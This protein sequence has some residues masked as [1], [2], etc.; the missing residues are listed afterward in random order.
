MS[1]DLGQFMPDVAAALCGAPNKGLSKGD[2]LRYGSNGS[3]SVDLKKGTAYDHELEQG[4]GVLWLIKRHKGL[5]GADA[6]AFMRDDLHLPIP[7]RRQANGSNLPIIDDHPFA[8]WND[9]PRKGKPK[10][11]IVKTYDY[12]DYSGS[13]LYQVVRFEPKGFGQRR[14]SGL[15]DKSWVWG[16]DAGEFMRKGPGSDWIR[17][18][19]KNFT[20]WKFKERKEFGDAVPH[21]LYR[22][23]ELRESLIEDTIIFIP[24]GEKDV[25]TIV[26]DLG[27]AATTNSGGAKHW[28][29]EHAEVFRGAHVVL[30]IDNDPQ[31][32]DRDGR[33]VFHE[34]GRPVITG[35]DRADMIARTLKGIAASI[36]VLDFGSLTENFPVKGDITDWV[37]SGGT[38]EGLY[39]LLDQVP[40]WTDPGFKSKL[41]GIQWKEVPNTK[42]KYEWLV[43]GL[44]ARREVFIIA[45]PTQSGKSFLA[46]D[47]SMSVARGLDWLKRRTVKGAVVYVAAESGIGVVSLRLPAYAAHHGLSFAQDIPILI[48]PKRINFFNDDVDVN[49]LISE[50]RAF[51]IECGHKVELVILDTW[52]AVTP[53]AKEN[54][55]SSVGPIL[56]RA[57]RVVDE[58]QTALGIVHHMNA[59]GARVRGHTSLTADVDSVIVVTASE[60]AKDADKRPIRTA[61]APK[62]KEG[63]NGLSW[64]FVLRSVDLGKD[65]DGDRMTSC[66]VD[67]PTK[68][69][70]EKADA[71]GPAPGEVIIKQTNV[72]VLF[73]ALCEAIEKYG[74]PVTSDIKAPP[75]SKMVNK[76]HWREEYARVASA[77]ERE[78]AKGGTEEEIE[79]RRAERVKKAVDRANEKFLATK[80]IDA[81]NPFVWLT[82]RPVAGFDVVRAGTG[83][84]GHKMEFPRTKSRTESQNEGQNGPETGTTEGTS[85]DDDGIGW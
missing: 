20:E 21:S 84:S 11:E 2:E 80:V 76:R 53:G 26:D 70:W 58:C 40:D 39:A 37:S 61:R 28:S 75:G 33:L 25:D 38:A 57:R 24:E 17:L 48:I 72:R 65:D 83:S 56:K 59:D 42:L 66:V 32:T 81:D 68:S 15:P 36:R 46:T 10:R 78:D 45:G 67:V 7:D 41:G 9:E 13:L 69:A 29:A 85:G 79:K 44:V 55:S 43:K 82:G 71:G 12:T 14:P 60:D 73:Q 34:D 23:V 63:V 49:L 47:L 74:V 1:E 16:L 5:E 4:G 35:R 51:E 64:D 52:S 8:P 22:T 31:K 50:I 6:I 18:N 54:D 62:V 19:E 77:G 27:L 30:P 3:L